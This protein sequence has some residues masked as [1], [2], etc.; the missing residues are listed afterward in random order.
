MFPTPEGNLQ[1]EDPR[2]LKLEG[3]REV[4]RE[5]GELRNVAQA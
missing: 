3:L 4:K 2:Q 5:D 1:R